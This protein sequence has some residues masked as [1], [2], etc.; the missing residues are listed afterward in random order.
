[1]N[2]RRHAPQTLNARILA[3]LVLIAMALTACG[4]APADVP[5]QEAPLTVEIDHA[6]AHWT[7]SDAFS[8]EEIDD[9]T[10]AAQAWHDAT[11]GHVALTFD[12]GPVSDD[13]PWTITRAPGEQPGY[14]AIT[15]V[16][17][18]H[19]V[20]YPDAIPEA[21]TW[22]AVAHELGH[23]LNVDHGGAGIMRA[24]HSRKACATERALTADDLA[25]FDAAHVSAT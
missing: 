10:S 6:Q 20:V 23:T 17:R 22:P 21:C 1:M 5:A 4:A 18:D 15:T 14:G 16:G 19:V 24:Q 11:G 3:L 2:I 25:L 9:I 12:I 13:A 8:T 7:I